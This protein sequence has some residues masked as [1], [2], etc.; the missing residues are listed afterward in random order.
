MT[1]EEAQAKIEA[2]LNESRSKVTEAMAVA[3]E[4][5]LVFGYEPDHIGTYTGAGSPENRWGDEVEGGTVD[6]EWYPS[7]WSSSSIYC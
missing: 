1:K 2:L 7:S 5:G 6:G 4:Y 3:D